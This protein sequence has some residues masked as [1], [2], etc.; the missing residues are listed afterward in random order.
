MAKTASLAAVLPLLFAAAAAQQIGA[1]VPEVHPK[2]PT[3]FCTT[4]GGCVQR[5]TSLVTDAL[6]R[7][8]HVVGNPA[9]PCS[10]GNK[11]QCPDATTCSKNC[12]LEGVDYGQMGVSTNGNAVTLSLFS[13]NANGTGLKTLSPRLYLVAEDDKNYEL[14][15][16]VNKELTYDVDVSKVGCGVNGALYLSEM[17][18]SGSR[19]AA[20]P[21]GAQYGTGYCDAQC[22]RSTFINGIVRSCSPFSWP[23]TS[24]ADSHPT[25]EP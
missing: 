6:S 23:L 20:N 8:L 3:L 14:F 1:A 24:G 15:Q 4:A 17:D 9:V 19:N 25:G 22:P 12:A 10:V 13:R 18:V 16:L 21:A 7:S 2:L 5:Q 11:T